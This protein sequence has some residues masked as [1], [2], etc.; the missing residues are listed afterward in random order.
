VSKQ[1]VFCGVSCGVSRLSRASGA[2]GEVRNSSR[3]TVSGSSG[4]RLIGVVQGSVA[5]GTIFNEKKRKNRV[6]KRVF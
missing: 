5:I 2:S 1:V 6:K 4:G 3:G